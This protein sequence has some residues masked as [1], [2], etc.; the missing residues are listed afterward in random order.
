M[1]LKKTY[2][3]LFDYFSEKIMSG[4]LSVG[5]KVPT[6]REISEELGVSRNSVREVMHMLE[7]NGILECLQ[8][9]GNYVRCEPEQYML[10]ITNMTMVLQ[11]ID[12]TDAFYLRMGYETVA[13]K[14]AINS[15]TDSEIEKI[16]KILLK[17]D[18]ITDPVESARLDAQFHNSIVAASHNRL[19]LM[20]YSMTRELINVFIKNFR[21]KI[22]ENPESAEALR[23]AYWNIYDALKDRD[24]ASGSLAIN[25]YFAIVEQQADTMEKTFRGF[26]Q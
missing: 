19:L 7:M 11:K 22:F 3:N 10:T 14:Q 8:G 21:V 6:E 16:E 9:S 20:Y 4:E 23:R 18:E 12:Y 2:Q 15:A 13:L 1:I 5:D 24:F 25:K 26:E 17:M